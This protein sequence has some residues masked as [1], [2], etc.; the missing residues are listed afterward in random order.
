VPSLEELQITVNGTAYSRHVSPRTSLADFLR[1][2]LNLTATHLGCEHGVCG[3]CTVFIDGRT[4][5]SCTVLALQVHNAEITT[6]EGLAQGD[7]LTPV[8][9]GFWERHGMQCGFC[10][11]GFLM[12]VT[13]LLR[14]R[15]DPTDA[16]IEEAL[17]GN[18][19]RC[20]GYTKI[21]EAVH[22]AVAITRARRNGHNVSAAG[23]AA[24]QS[25]AV[26]VQ[27]PTHNEVPDRGWTPGSGTAQPDITESGDQEST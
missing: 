3:A 14:D 11:P 24:P 7:T 20:T 17:G 12:T 4:A 9:Q 26:S 8:Q 13:E 22:E 6:A 2:D 25:E 16:Q 5:R 1:E 18:L 10:T 27:T 19:C 15:P 21:V 23:R